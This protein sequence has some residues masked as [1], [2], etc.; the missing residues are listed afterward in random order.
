MPTQPPEDAANT[1][2]LKHIFR[3]VTS[4]IPVKEA[5][6]SMSHLNSA[7]KQTGWIIQGK[8]ENPLHKFIYTAIENNAF[9]RHLHC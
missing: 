1:L 5:L 2:L 7:W 9:L 4:A 8:P 6:C 3:M